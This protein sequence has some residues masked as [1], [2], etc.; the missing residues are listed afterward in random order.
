[1]R[2]IST[3]QVYACPTT[4]VLPREG[5]GADYRCM[6]FTTGERAAPHLT[7]GVW[8]CL[9]TN[10]ATCGGVRHI[11]LGDEDLVELQQGVRGARANRAHCGPASCIQGFG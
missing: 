4:L 8:W 9:A 2:Y 1:M 6:P 3:T 5:V 11:T 7:S 10:P